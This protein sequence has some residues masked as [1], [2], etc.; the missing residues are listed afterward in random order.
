MNFSVILWVVRVV[1][2]S[3]FLEFGWYLHCFEQHGSHH[4]SRFIG[5]TKLRF[6]TPYHWPTVKIYTHFCWLTVIIVEP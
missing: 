5:G 4:A 2:L 3:A 6:C 1:M